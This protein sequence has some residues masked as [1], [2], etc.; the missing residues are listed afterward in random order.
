VVGEDPNAALD[1]LLAAVNA[2]PPGLLSWD[3]WVEVTTDGRHVWGDK[4]QKVGAGNPLTC[5]PSYAKW[6]ASLPSSPTGEN[7]KAWCSDATR[8]ALA[9]SK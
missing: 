6:V 4:A 9:A 2:P 5:D 8:A 7:G 3:G 1:V